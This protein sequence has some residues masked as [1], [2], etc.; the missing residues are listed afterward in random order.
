MKTSSWMCC[1]AILCCAPWLAAAEPAVETDLRR[2]VPAEAHL[3]IY[4]KH[5]PERDYQTVYL[6]EICQTVR[7][8]KLVERF[9]EIF[10]SRMPE[11]KLNNVKGKEK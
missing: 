6:E 10:T 9:L 2:C 5:N 4:G 11:Q 8:E 7:D 3:A 1:V